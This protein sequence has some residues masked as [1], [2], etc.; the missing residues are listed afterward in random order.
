VVC[1]PI[2]LLSAPFIWFFASKNKNSTTQKISDTLENETALLCI[3]QEVSNN[4]NDRNEKVISK[5]NSNDNDTNALGS[6]IENYPSFFDKK[7]SQ[8]SNSIHDQHTSAFI[9]KSP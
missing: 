3:L 1:F 9:S 4:R 2:F 7:N 6:P 5:E 8:L